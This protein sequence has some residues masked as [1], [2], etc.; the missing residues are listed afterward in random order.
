MRIFYAVV[1]EENIKEQILAKTA[2]IADCLKT[3]RAIDIF[4]IHV[5]L[6]FIGETNVCDL[7]KYI[8]VLDDAAKDAGPSVIRLK[9]ISSFFRGG[10][11]LIFMKAFHEIELERIRDGIISR[12][13]L[14]QSKYMPHVSLFR[15]AL[16]KDGFDMK[17][18][19]D[20][21]GPKEIA[22]PAAGISL[23]ESRR[24]NGKLVYITLYERKLEGEKHGS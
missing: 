7:Q 13:D 20:M 11:H 6:E 24:I 3:G 2:F 22:I 23:M 5:T 12:L 21:A 10:C 9:E 17:K 19:S 4:N 16:L 8:D 14:L 1:P 18:I 15:D